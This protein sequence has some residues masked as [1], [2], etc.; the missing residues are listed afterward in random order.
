MRIRRIGTLQGK[1]PTTW[2]TAAPLS[3]RKHIRARRAI[4]QD[5]YYARA[6]KLLAVGRGDRFHHRFLPNLS[7]R[8][9]IHVP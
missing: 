3:D 9:T 6:V 1:S 5:Q 4:Q 7:H 8:S 2:P